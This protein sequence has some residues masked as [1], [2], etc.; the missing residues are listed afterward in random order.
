MKLSAHLR[1]LL[2]LTAAAC[3]GP[4]CAIGPQD[5]RS[6]RRPGTQASDDDKE[7]GVRELIAHQ[8]YVDAVKLAAD[9]HAEAPDDPGRE[10]EWRL[11][12]VALLLERGRR[13]SFE[14]RDLEALDFFQQAR[15]VGL[16]VPQIKPW[17]DSTLDKL[18]RRY[19]DEAHE[20]H[21]Q[22]NLE[23]AVES[24]EQALALVPDYSIAIDGLARVLLQQNHRAGQS[25]EYYEE[26]V[27]SL[28]AY[29]LNDAAHDFRASLKYQDSHERAG[30]RRAQTDTLL[31]DERVVLAVKLE[32]ARQWSAARGEYRIATLVDATHAEALAGLARMRKEAKAA[33]LLREAE[34]FTLRG[35]FER[36]E[37]AL[38]EG[39]ALTAQQATEFEIAR[40]GL[41]AGK[42]RE[43][44]N[45][46][47]ALEADYRF[48]DAIAAYA[49]LLKEAVSFEDAIARKET[50]EDFV[51]KA[52]EH[53]AAAAAATDPA[54]ELAA[55]R[56]VM[57]VYPE[58]KDTRERVEK[59]EASLG[60]PENDE[61]R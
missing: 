20:W 42:L 34:R 16:D 29:W 38:T 14:D 52:I 39:E 31:A 32:E 61:P 8:R 25:Q 6:D 60:K 22:D 11:A 17:I 1:L 28:D 13:A 23:R 44:Y 12:T 49:L 19:S 9:R 54:A 30:L 4:A 51:A 59:L 37:A 53:Y 50:L 33:E 27:H 46:A 57:I 10:L 56:Q 40:E 15:D 58:Y 41:A 43:K 5:T 36:A 3:L 18:A 2:A 21:A 26:G 7:L 24:Y 48:E 55:L 47:R 45:V 35:L